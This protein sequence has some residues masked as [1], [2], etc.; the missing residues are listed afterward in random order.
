LLHELQVIWIF[1]APGA[2][3]YLNDCCYRSFRISGY[4]LLKELQ[5]IWM[6]VATGIPES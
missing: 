2:S 5:H 3:G 4:L 1:V 6:I